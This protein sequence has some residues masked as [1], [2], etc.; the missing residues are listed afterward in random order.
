MGQECKIFNCLHVSGS[1]TTAVVKS[2]SDNKKIFLVLNL[3]DFL[4]EHRLGMLQT[5][6]NQ[7]MDVVWWFIV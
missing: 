4:K 7:I 1:V 5:G 6:S 3:P 2:K